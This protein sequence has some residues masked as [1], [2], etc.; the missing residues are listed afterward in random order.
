MILIVKEPVVEV[1][2]L[3]GEG[4]D[5]TRFHRILPM[6]A[7]RTLQVSL[8]GTYMCSPVFVPQMVGMALLPGADTPKVS[9]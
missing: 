1:L 6:L 8:A 9:T 2:V 4:I 3:P 7:L 5:Q